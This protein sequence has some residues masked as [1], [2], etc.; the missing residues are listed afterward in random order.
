MEKLY[1]LHDEGGLRPHRR[2]H[3]TDPPRARLP[4]RAGAPHASARQPGLPIPDGPG[5]HRPAHR[6]RGGAGV[7]PCRR[8][9]RGHRGHRRRR[10]VLPRVRGDGAGVPRPGVDGHRA[11]RRGRDRLRP[12]DVTAARLGRGSRVLRRAAAC[13]GSSRGRA[14]GE[15]RAPAVRDDDLHRRAARDGRGSSLPRP[16]PRRRTAPCARRRAGSRPATRT[17]PTTPSSV[18]ASERSSTAPRSGS[19][20]RPSRACRRSRTTSSTSTRSTRSPSTC[21]ARVRAR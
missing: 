3:S 12:R 19:G 15:P 14:R 7:L 13:D 4:R 5:A 20:H 18:S 16:T 9:G 11:P 21:S 1:E 8:E 2:G 6:R 10:G 17:S